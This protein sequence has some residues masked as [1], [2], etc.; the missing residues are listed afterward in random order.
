MLLGLQVHIFIEQGIQLVEYI[1]DS[2]S[3]LLKDFPFFKVFCD[4][5]AIF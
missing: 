3:F 1:K 4:P 5:K 2:R